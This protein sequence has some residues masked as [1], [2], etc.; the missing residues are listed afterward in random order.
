ML[1]VAACQ[2][3][4]T[5]T[6]LPTAVPTSTVVATAAATSATESAD[7]LEKLV[8]RSY[9]S[10]FKTYVVP[11]QE[12]TGGD[13]D[14]LTIQH[15][16]VGLT[17]LEIPLEAGVYQITIEGNP[18]KLRHDGEVS[19]NF[20]VK[21]SDDK[22]TNAIP[23]AK[24]YS[25]TKRPGHRALLT[26]LFWT[27]DQSLADFVNL[28]PDQDEFPGSIETMQPFFQSVAIPPAEW[29]LLVTMIRKTGKAAWYGA[30]PTQ[31]LFLYYFETAPQYLLLVQPDKIHIAPGRAP[32]AVQPATPP[33]ITAGTPG[34]FQVGNMV[35]V[36]GVDGSG[37]FIRSA[38]ST[39][40]NVKFRANEGDMFVLVDGPQQADDQEWWML[41]DTVDKTRS[42]WAPRLYLIVVTPT[43]QAPIQLGGT[44]TTIP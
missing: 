14:F 25:L 16:F 26:A 43:V 32:Q 22:I 5:A 24:V 30:D 19:Q 18:G 21:L 11:Q 15:H 29:P 9:P 34:E 20:Q 1:I 42:G 33:T 27:E 38:P 31:Y 35:E 6:P 36:A 12:L 4:P 37:L 39:K 28:L 10:G 17:P 8:V 41:Q 2:T 7:S 40:S 44:P 13:L 3:Q 23:F